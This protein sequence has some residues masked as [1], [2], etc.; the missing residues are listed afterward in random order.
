MLC[1]IKLR[2]GPK[3]VVIKYMK[4]I[5]WPRPRHEKPLPASGPLFR[6][7]HMVKLDGKKLKGLGEFYDLKK[8]WASNLDNIQRF[9]TL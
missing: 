3:A 8:A 1:P 6:F 9:F 5:T 4:N 7:L 2:N